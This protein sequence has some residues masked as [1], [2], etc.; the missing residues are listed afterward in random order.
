MRNFPPGLILTFAVLCGVLA[1][2]ATRQATTIWP[3]TDG[4][5]Q[6]LPQPNARLLLLGDDRIVSSTAAHWL[7]QRGLDVITKS[8]VRR[9]LREQRTGPLLTGMDSAGLAELGQRAGAQW[10]VVAESQHE[11]IGDMRPGGDHHGEGDALPTLYSSSV[12]IRGLA[13]ASHRVEWNGRA[14]FLFLGTVSVH[15][16]DEAFHNLTCQALATAWGFRPPGQ[17]EIAS[18]AMCDPEPHQPPP[19]IPPPDLDYASY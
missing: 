10:V 13:T 4:T 1:G 14:E 19:P 17:H 12:T 6:N 16:L 18:A 2:C 7:Q 3:V 5:H 9:L 11:T 8:R 15:R